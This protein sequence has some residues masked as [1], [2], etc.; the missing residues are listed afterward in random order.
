MTET[1]GKE[2]SALH[3]VFQ[4]AARGFSSALADLRE[5]SVLV[6]SLIDEH[7]LKELE[8]AVR[9]YQGLGDALCEIEKRLRTDIESLAID[10]TKPN[11]DVQDS[12]VIEV[13]DEDGR[14]VMRVRGHRR[15]MKEFD[16]SIKAILRSGSSVNHLHRSSLISLVSAVESFVSTL[17]HQFYSTHPAALNIKEKQ[18][19]FDELSR[20]E[21]MDDARSYIVSWKVE[22]L[23][24]GSLEDWF[25]FF[26]KNLKLKLSV[27]SRRMDA[28]VEIFQRRNLFVHNEGVV[29]NI[30]LSKVKN[31]KEKGHLLN[32]RIGV[33]KKYLFAAIDEIESS[34]LDVAYEIWARCEK[35][36]ELRP[37][38]IVATSYDALLQRRWDVAKDVASLVVADP[39]SSE[40]PILMAKVNSW[41]ARLRLGDQ[42]AIG[43]IEKF[44]VSA[45]GDVFRLAKCCL[46]E[47]NEKAL[48]L[49][50]DL[51]GQN[52]IEFES[53]SEW[54]LFEPQRETSEFQRWLSEIDPAK[55]VG[56]EQ[57]IG[58]GEAT[59]LE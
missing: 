40:L 56:A 36:N 22:N 9:K 27:A 49:A 38:L 41:I 23:L 29:N 35:S 26:S 7:R 51:F 3:H 13:G 15:E 55:G 1:E 53:L 50:K 47:Q 11:T 20:F 45:K 44:D 32:K 10:N 30:Y 2:Q 31:G 19:T 28:L 18:F 39:A 21:T 33:T 24:R 52:K 16:R 17:L 6:E 46:L 42:A 54:P 14:K 57:A 8:Q 37:H 12:V 58:N 34:F 25:E 4:K 48:A 59:S 5:F 43:E